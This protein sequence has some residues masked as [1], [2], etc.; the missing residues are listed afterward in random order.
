MLSVLTGDPREIADELL[1]H[2]DVDL[3]TF[4]GGVAIGKHIAARAVYK[5][6]VLELGGNDP[7]IVMD[8]ADLD[9]AARWQPPARTAT[10][11]SA[12]RRS[13]I[14]VHERVADP[15]IEKLL[16]AT[17][18]V[19]YR[20]PARPGHRHGHGDRRGGGDRVRAA[21]I[22][23]VARARGCSPATCAAAPCIRRPCSTACGPRCAWCARR[24]L[25]PGLARHPFLRCRRG[26]THRQRHGLWSV[27]GG[28]HPAAG[29]H[30][31]LRLGTRRRH[32]QRARGA[33]LPAGTDAVRRIKDSGLGYKE[34]VLEAMKSFTNTKTYSLPG[35]AA[36]GWRRPHVVCT[37]RRAAEDR[38]ADA[39]FR[40]ART[41]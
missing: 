1:T 10:P 26:D 40:G 15:F 37:S 3:V 13:A 14:L 2:P 8:D 16:A 4:T 12:A 11:A 24:P 31:A 28:L 19:K 36:A 41:P 6:Q 29:P 17:A 32:G 7:L 34:G 33:G 39:R 18:R 25:R 27:L 20:R 5:R 38:A 9:E 23:A 30:H 35:S 22:E 21:V